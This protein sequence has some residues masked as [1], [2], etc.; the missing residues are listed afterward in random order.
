MIYSG[1]PCLSK[2]KGNMLKGNLPSVSQY[3][4]PLIVFKTEHWSCFVLK[5]KHV[6]QSKH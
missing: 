3:I 1:L 4:G 2:V 5:Q 6:L